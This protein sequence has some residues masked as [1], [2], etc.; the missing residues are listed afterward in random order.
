MDPETIAY[1]K[2]QI[3]FEFHGFQSRGAPP[4]GFE[5]R[6]D[7]PAGRYIDDAFHAL[8]REHIWSKSWLL[9][10][11]ADEVPEVGSYKLWRAAARRS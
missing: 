1:L 5:P 4:G 10:A 8:E 3:D 2:S 9:A 7:I 11:P 6:P